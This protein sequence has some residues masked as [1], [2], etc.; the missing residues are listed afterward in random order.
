MEPAVQATNGA[1]TLCTNTF[2]PT[3]ANVLLQNTNIPLGAYFLDLICNCLCKQNRK[4]MLISLATDCKSQ[5]SV[6]CFCRFSL[7]QIFQIINCQKVQNI[8]SMCAAH[9]QHCSENTKKRNVFKSSVVFFFLFQACRREHA[10]L[11]LPAHLGNISNLIV[12]CQ[13]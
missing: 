12:L 10:I 11:S 1:K 6:G 3:H 5:C 7:C 9:N 8:L 13:Q 4:N 2:T